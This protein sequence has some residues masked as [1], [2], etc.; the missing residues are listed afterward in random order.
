MGTLSSQSFVKGFRWQKC[1]CCLG[2]GRIIQS[3]WV[4]NKFSVK[5]KTTEKWLV[6][7]LDW[8]LNE[9]VL[10][11]LTNCICRCWNQHCDT[12]LLILSKLV[13][14]NL[15]YYTMVL[16]RNQEKDCGCETAAHTHYQHCGNHPRLADV[17]GGPGVVLWFHFSLWHQARLSGTSYQADLY[18]RGKKLGI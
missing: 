14:R 6:T 2:E 7:N 17:N 5:I 13:D 1:F 3:T 9:I 16:L 12:L 4:E 18:Y 15:N 8:L 11:C 10:N